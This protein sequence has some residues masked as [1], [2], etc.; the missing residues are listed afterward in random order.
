MNKEKVMEYVYQ[1][2]DLQSIC[3]KDIRK[4]AISKIE[5]ELNSKPV[6]PKVFDKW[7]K[8]QEG[9]SV[10]LQRLTLVST[11]L[12]YKIKSVTEDEFTSW[13]YEDVDEYKH[14]QMCID[15]IINGYEVEK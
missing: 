11:S 4:E 3:D 12:I 6:M 8:E 7:L 15:A 13:I 14:Y 10:A 9:S 5:K 2:S 1:L